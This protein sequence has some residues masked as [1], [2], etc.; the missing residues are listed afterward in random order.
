MDSVTGGATLDRHPE[1]VKQAAVADRIVLTKTD[2]PEAEEAASLNINGVSEVGFNPNRHKQHA[3]HFTAD[4]CIGCH[5]CESACSEKNDLPPHLRGV[6]V[7]APSTS[8]FTRT[9]RRRDRVR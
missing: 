5:A 1:S 8:N 2:L 6:L 3:F 9:P 4:N 7:W